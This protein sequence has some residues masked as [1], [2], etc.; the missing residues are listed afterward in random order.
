MV[1]TIRFELTT[2]STPRKCATKLRYV[3]IRTVIIHY[4]IMGND[5]IDAMV[6]NDIDTVVEFFLFFVRKFKGIN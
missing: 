4:L 5:F 1:G 3:P 2:P 6:L